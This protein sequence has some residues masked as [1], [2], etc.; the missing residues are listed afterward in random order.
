MSTATAPTKAP[1]KAFAFNAMPV[2]FRDTAGDE[3]AN[4]K[5]HRV[6]VQAR[7]PGVVDHWFWGRI[8]HDMAGLR[9]KDR[10]PFDWR[11]DPDEILGYADEFDAGDKGLQLGGPLQSIKEGDRAS[12]V[13]HRGTGGQP[14]DA[15]IYWDEWD[16]KLEFLDEGFVA[17]VNGQTV[18]GPCVIVREWTLRGCAITPYGVDHT[19]HTK[20]SADGSAGDSIPV[21]YKPAEGTMTKDATKPA[22]TETAE[23][24]A[25]PTKDGTKPAEGNPTK[26]A[27]QSTTPTEATQDNG[28]SELGRFMDRFGTERGAE[29]FRDSVP[30]QSALEREVDHLR[31]ELATKDEAVKSAESKLAAVNVGETEP[32]DTGKTKDEAKTKGWN[33]LFRK[34]GS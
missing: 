19:T 32:V 30:Y 3:R 18:E 16:N 6:T 7:T 23:T 21:T 33:D 11:H 28:R 26:P 12:E 15:S 10:I 9:H 31:K 22:E 20:F 29:Y 4:P 2:A 34:Q 5:E 1:R 27:E 17:T 8:C 13:I 25:E 14:Y 24:E